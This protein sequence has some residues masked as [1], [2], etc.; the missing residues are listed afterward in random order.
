MP[1]RRNEYV[2]APDG[3]PARVVGTWADQK[4]HYVDRYATLFATG[5]KNKWPRRAYVELFSGPG[6]SLDRHSQSRRREGTFI[7]GSAMR[8]LER[9]FTDYAFVD[10]DR[11][12]ARAL[13]ERI[14]RSGARQAKRVTVFVGDCNNAPGPIR[15]AL[16]PGAITLAFVDPTTWQVTFDAIAR[17]TDGRAIDLLFTFHAAT[18]RR[19]VQDDPPALTQFFGTG[20][21]KAALGVPREERTLALLELFNR[22]LETLGYLPG[23]AE[24]AVPVLNTVR[25]PIYSLVLFSKNSRGLDFWRKAT[26]ATQSGQLYLGL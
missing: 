25:R 3:L 23:S 9:E 18:M 2:V 13:E 8:A 10:I 15:D 19:M 11:R 20:Q 16:P 24:L 12:A 26:A 21:W 22:Q 4:V 17:L 5:M 14:A 7:T 1:A 6:V